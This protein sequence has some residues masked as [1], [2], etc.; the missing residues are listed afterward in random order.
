[1]RN[2]HPDAAVE[3]Q[4]EKR[5][6]NHHLE[7]IS[8]DLWV[9]DRD[10]EDDD[11]VL[12]DRGS[13]G[14]AVSAV[15]SATSFGIHLPALTDQFVSV[16]LKDA[17]MKSLLFSGFDA[18]SRDRFERNTRRLLRRYALNLI[19]SASNEIQIRAAKYIRNQSRLIAN[20]IL[21]NI[22]PLEH[23]SSSTMD[24]LV[25]TQTALPTLT[26][27]QKSERFLEQEVPTEEMEDPSQP[28]KEQVPD[29]H[30]SD[31]D[32]SD[33]DAHSSSQETIDIQPLLPFLIYSDQFEMLREELMNFV[34]PTQLANHKLMDWSFP[35]PQSAIECTHCM[36]Q[37]QRC[38]GFPT[39]GVVY[40]TLKAAKAFL[41]SCPLQNHLH[42]H[43]LALIS[44]CKFIRISFLDLLEFGVDRA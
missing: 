42:Y 31:S 19:K 32:N 37:E 34:I 35:A 29:G 43:C 33:D 1:M 39:E 14:S 36:Q 20:R 8:T 30:W 15:S 22:T 17:G 4:A 5:A 27:V 40:E 10:L 25:K 13:Q 24:E 38:R 23:A 41:S 11:S 12:S 21:Y 16:V 7:A 28:S 2:Q 18:M 9:Y 6:E 44:Q 26:G 3:I